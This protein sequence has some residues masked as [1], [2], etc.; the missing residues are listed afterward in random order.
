MA[1]VTTDELDSILVVSVALKCDSGESALIRWNCN[2]CGQRLTERHREL[3]GTMTVCPQCSKPGRIPSESAP[4]LELADSTKT[5]SAS[6]RSAQP[7]ASSE[8]Q[9]PSGGVHAPPK[10]RSNRPGFVRVLLVVS[11]VASI[12]LTIAAVAYSNG[13]AALSGAAFVKVRS[14]DS[15]ILR[16]NG[17]YLLSAQPPQQ[18]SDFVHARWR[19]LLGE[20]GTQFKKEPTCLAPELERSRASLLGNVNASARAASPLSTKDLLDL[21]SR[22]NTF[23]E[24]VERHYRSACSNSTICLKLVAD[25]R[26]AH[27]E[28]L[29]RVL[30]SSTKTDIEGRFSF[31]PLPPGEYLLWSE[32]SSALSRIE[33]RIPLKL[34]PWSKLKVD[35]Q[36]D[37]AHTIE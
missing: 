28:F 24:A 16:G 26:E 23:T 31:P 37:N 17:I 33:W 15:H 32:H 12:L 20:L 5:A 29:G 6:T 14:G 8:I 27:A 22:L 36:N 2:S 10:P 34:R 30:R 25:I 18:A 9:P 19:T 7:V 21:L 3:A 35:L 4:D 13:T 11:A 1:R